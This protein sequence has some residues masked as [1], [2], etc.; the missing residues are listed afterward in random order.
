MLIITMATTISTMATTINF[1]VYAH[2]VHDIN[3]YSA[4][5]IDTDHNDDVY[6]YAWC[7]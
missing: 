6:L 5:L 3:L 4:Y 1:S 7:T 2:D